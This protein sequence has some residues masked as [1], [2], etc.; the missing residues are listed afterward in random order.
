MA[1]S[2][3]CARDSDTPCSR[4]RPGDICPQHRSPPHRGDPLKLHTFFVLW[5]LLK[6]VCLFTMTNNFP[7]AHNSKF[8]CN[9]L[10]WYCF[11][12]SLCSFVDAWTNKLDG[13]HESA[14]HEGR[15]RHR[16]AVRIQWDRRKC[17]ASQPSPRPH[18]CPC[19]DS[20]GGRTN[21]HL[22]KM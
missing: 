13:L 22:Q 17:R 10:R 18:R 9:N 3:A 1:V 12:F 11:Q 14:T 4:T 16:C 15:L 5:S 20:P 6:I 2:G 19:T 7:R 21:S 8:F